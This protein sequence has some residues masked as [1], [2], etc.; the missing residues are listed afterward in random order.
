MDLLKGNFLINTKE[1]AVISNEIFRDAEYVGLYFSA[2]WCPPCQTFL[3]LLKRLYQDAHLRQV[4]LEIIFIPSDTDEH[5]MTRFFVEKHGPWYALPIGPVSLS[6]RK[7]FQIHNIPKLIILD[8]TGKIVTNQAREDIETC[9]DPL[10]KWFPNLN[11]KQL[12]E[13]EASIIGSS[14]KTIS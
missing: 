8:N 2:S 12:V 3:P 1:E 6:L 7:K 10:S 4:K 11:E 13:D 9:D 5:K 14:K